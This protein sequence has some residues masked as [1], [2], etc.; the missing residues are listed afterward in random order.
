ME[1]IPSLEANS[2]YTSQ[3]V[4]CL[5]LM[6]PDCPSPYSQEPATRPYPKPDVSSPTYRILFL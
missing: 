3:E 2:R 5:Y 1:Q 6:V 4:P